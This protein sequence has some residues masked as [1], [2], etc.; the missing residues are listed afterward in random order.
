M[1]NLRSIAC[2]LVRLDAMALNTIGHSYTTDPQLV[3]Q[4]FYGQFK[5]LVSRDTENLAD[6]DGLYQNRFENDVQHSL[7][8]LSD[9]EILGILVDVRT[10]TYYAQFVQL[11][12]LLYTTADAELRYASKIIASNLV[13]PETS[14]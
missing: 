5:D 7:E 10:S 14:D 4:S 12:T 11:R 8:T 6:D 9:D 1:S 2:A 3:N 13:V